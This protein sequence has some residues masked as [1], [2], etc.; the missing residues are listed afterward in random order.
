M[1]DRRGAYRNLVGRPEG[2][3]LVGRPRRRWEDITMDLN[4]VGRRSMDWTELAQGRAG[5]GHL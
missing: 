4:E 5:S 3:R 2:R 1:G